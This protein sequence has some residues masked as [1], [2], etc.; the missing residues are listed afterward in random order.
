M[1][2]GV[3]AG[4]MGLQAAQSIIGAVEKSQ[5]AKITE[6]HLNEIDGQMQ[7]VQGKLGQIADRRTA[8]SKQHFNEVN[9]IL[10]NYNTQASAISNLKVDDYK[11]YLHDNGQMSTNDYIS[12]MRDIQENQIDAQ[13]D[14]K[15][16]TAYETF[17]FQKARQQL[18]NAKELVAVKNTIAQR[19]L[20]G[21]SI[22][23]Q[24]VS[25]AVSSESQKMANL[26]RTFNTT[27]QDAIYAHTQSEDKITQNL[28]QEEEGMS[29][30]EFQGFLS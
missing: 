15:I 30:N 2:L 1:A 11:Q 5:Q 16:K 7:E 20:K 27:Y 17:D 8:S 9:Q 22:A 13:R 21:S 12:K 14:E 23:S 18:A 19:G 6:K 10:N 4:L 3:M 28:S 29:V 26:A 24:T 25:Q